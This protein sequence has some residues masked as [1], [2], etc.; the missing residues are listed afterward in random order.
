MATAAKIP[1]RPEMPFNI[2]YVFQVPYGR[3]RATPMYCYVNR[4]LIHSTRYH[5][6]RLSYRVDTLSQFG[7]AVL[8]P[9]VSLPSKDRRLA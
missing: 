4:C 7:C 8:P 3:V 5:V 9:V 6:G 2:D 1:A